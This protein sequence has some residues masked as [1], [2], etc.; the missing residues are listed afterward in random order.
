MTRSQAEELLKQEVSV[1]LQ[2]NG[3]LLAQNMRILNWRVAAAYQA[4]QCRDHHFYRVPITLFSIK[5]N[6]AAGE[7]WNLALKLGVVLFSPRFGQ[8]GCRCE[9]QFLLRVSLFFCCFRGRKEVSL[10]ETPAKRENIL[11]LYLL[12]L[13]GECYSSKALGTKNKGAHPTA[14]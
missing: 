9:H 13:Q 14:P 10:S 2:V 12:N 7:S 8:K 1:W 11:C 6:K 3:I 5:S 4:R